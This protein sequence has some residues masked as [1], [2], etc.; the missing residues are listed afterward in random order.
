M[1]PPDVRRQIEALR[2]AANERRER[3]RAS[4]AEGAA[5]FEAG[6]ADGLG[7]ALGV[8][9]A[10]DVAERRDRAADCA[11]ETAWALRE[12]KDTL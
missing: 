9:A 1:T 3:Y 11:D 7:S 6:R 10:H 5:L 2:K 4:G 12:T 8:L